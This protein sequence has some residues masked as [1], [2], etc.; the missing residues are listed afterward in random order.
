[1][2][3]YSGYRVICIDDTDSQQTKLEH[4]GNVIIFTTWKQKEKEN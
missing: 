4:E 3:S 2:S 1:M